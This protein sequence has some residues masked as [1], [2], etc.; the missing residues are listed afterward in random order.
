MVTI[1]PNATDHLSRRPAVLSIRLG[2]GPNAYLLEKKENEYIR[3]LRDRDRRRSEF[4][5][6]N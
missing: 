5:I 2:A 3:L 4:E 1:S 6:A